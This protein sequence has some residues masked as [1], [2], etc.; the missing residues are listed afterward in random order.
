MNEHGPIGTSPGKTAVTFRALRDLEIQ[1]FAVDAHR[2][3]G[4]DFEC[5]DQPRHLTAR[6]PDRLAGFDAQRHRE[7]VVAFA[8]AFHAMLEYRLALKRGHLA[9]RFLRLDGG[10]DTRVDRLRIRQGDAR[11]DCAGVFVG[12]LE[13]GV[14]RDG[15]VSEVIGVGRLEHSRWSLDRCTSNNAGCNWTT[16]ILHASSRVRSSAH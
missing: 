7:F 6:I 5:I 12:D 1:H 15:L 8:E 10:R 14:R 11:R 13:I 4:G 9:Q 2:F 3:L 16:L